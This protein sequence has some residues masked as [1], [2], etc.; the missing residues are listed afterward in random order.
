M[1]LRALPCPSPSLTA[2]C[3]HQHSQGVCLAST[4]V[5]ELLTCPQ[6]PFCFWVL[7]FDTRSHIL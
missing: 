4:G 6:R 2:L 5:A 7:E 1:T 3:Q